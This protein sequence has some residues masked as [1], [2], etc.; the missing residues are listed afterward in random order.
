MDGLSSNKHRCNIFCYVSNENNEVGQVI[1]KRL[2]NEKVN[3]FIKTIFF[4]TL[5]GD[6][7]IKSFF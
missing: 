5:V 6:T 1:R 4:I 2:R 7:L 3:A